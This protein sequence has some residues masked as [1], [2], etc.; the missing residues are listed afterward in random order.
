MTSLND[1]RRRNVTCLDINLTDQIK[2]QLLWLSKLC[3]VT[4]SRAKPANWRT[5]RLNYINATAQYMLCSTRV[6]NKDFQCFFTFGRFRNNFFKH[7]IYKFTFK[8]TVKGTVHPQKIIF[9]YIILRTVTKNS[10]IVITKY[11]W[12]HR[13]R[14]K[15]SNYC[16]RLS[17]LTQIIVSLEH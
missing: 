15:N 9:K 1:V 13:Y 12:Y 3:D 8:S 2:S 4:C 7:S 17:R 6:Q 14:E 16:T 11:T 5:H 10:T